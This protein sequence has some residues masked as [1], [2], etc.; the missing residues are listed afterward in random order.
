MFMCRLRD[1]LR[2]DVFFSFFLFFFFLFLDWGT[3]SNH[4]KRPRGGPT[5]PRIELATDSGGQGNQLTAGQHQ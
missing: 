3:C 5:D 1:V 2:N 4:R